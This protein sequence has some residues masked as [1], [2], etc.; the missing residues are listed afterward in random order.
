MFRSSA[1][2]KSDTA[3]GGVG[4]SEVYMLNKEG[5]RTLPWGTPDFIS[6]CFDWVLL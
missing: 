4:M 2:P 1:Y 5:E 6:F 3:G